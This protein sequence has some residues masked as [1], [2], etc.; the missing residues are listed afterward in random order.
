METE[1]AFVRT[2][3]RIELHTIAEVGL[4]LTLVVN[5]CNTESEDTIGL[6]HT[7]HNLRLFKLRMLIV[8]LFDRLENLL[9]GL[10]I[11]CLARVFR[12]QLLH[13]CFDFHRNY[14]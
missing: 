8:N 11:L 9:N 12:S 14:I 2:D 10:Q 6:Y 7:L 4:H 3:S 1:T 13:D 5:P